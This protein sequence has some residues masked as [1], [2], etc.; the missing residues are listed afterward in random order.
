VPFAVDEYPVGALSLCCAYPPLGVTVRA[1]GPRRGLDRRQVLA[2]ED[3]AEGA[4]ELGVAVPDEE[5]GGADP[6]SDIHEQVAGLLGCLCAAGVGGHAEDVHTPG[7]HFHDKQY[8]QALEE[9]RVHV[10]EIAGQQAVSLSVQERPPGGVHTAGSRPVAPGP[11]DPP[12]RR[13]AEVVTEPGQF[14]MHPAISPGWVLLRKPQQHQVADL[15]AGPGRPGRFG[16]VHLH[17]I[18]RRCQASEVPGV[19]S[20]WERNTAC[21]SRA[22]AA[23]T[24]RSAQSGFGRVTWRRSTVTSCLS[25]MIS[26]SL[27][28]WP[29]PRRSSQPK[30]WIMIR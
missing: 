21:S 26:A 29:R 16:Y 13:L 27:D 10:Q 1:W 8:V 15:L 9:D 23:R 19:T 22:S 5:A 7:S 20:R 4:G 6:V 12:D 25:I 24:A 30:P 11:Q 17:L 3:L 18:R 28:A 2:C 14:A